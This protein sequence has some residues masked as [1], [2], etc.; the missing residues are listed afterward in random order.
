MVFQLR[1]FRSPLVFFQKDL[2]CPFGVPMLGRNAMHLDIWEASQIHRVDSL[3]AVNA[4]KQ[5]IHPG[6][7]NWSG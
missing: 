1:N 3:K 7:K 5:R 2:T 4:K 6:K